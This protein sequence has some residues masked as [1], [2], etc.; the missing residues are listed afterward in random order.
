MERMLSKKSTILKFMLPGSV[1]F[2]V[3]MVVPLFATFY[4]SFMNWDGVGAISFAG[5]KNYVD[6]IINGN[7][8]FWPSV[9][10]SFIVVFLSLLVQEPIALLLAL[11]LNRG[12]RGE[13][14]LRTIYFIPMVVSTI[15][16]AQLFIKIY[17]PTYGLLNAA[18]NALG[19]GSLTHAWLAETDTAIWA[20]YIPMIWQYIGY[21]MLLYYGGLKSISPDI[22]EAA[23]IDGATYPQICRKILIPMIMPV[24]E[25]CVVIALV[26][27]LKTF[28]FIYVMTG[29]GPVNS[30]AVPATLLYELLIKRSNYG[31]G[32]V[33]ATF[34]VAEC[35]LFT[36]IFQAVFKRLRRE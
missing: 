31:A 15:V 35:M 2:L 23:E 29:G 18:L 14:A 12:I 25:S 10:H 9:G 3:V 27:S 16:I 30:T 33:V 1:V 22:I 34:I 7:Y 6:I 11:A 17:N 5:L 8:H 19:L 21:H 24:I 28:D 13:K 26:G 4:L 32:S 20:V 36:V